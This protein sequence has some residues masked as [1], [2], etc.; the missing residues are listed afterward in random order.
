MG[1]GQWPDNSNALLEKSQE[2]GEEMKNTATTLVT[3]ENVKIPGIS[4]ILDIYRFAS[5]SKLLRTTW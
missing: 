5:L 3:V 2:V 4:R 1:K